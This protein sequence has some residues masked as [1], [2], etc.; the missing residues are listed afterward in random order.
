MCPILIF[1]QINF[2][3]I[4][5]QY[6]FSLQFSTFFSPFYLVQA[7]LLSIQEL[8]VP[9]YQPIENSIVG[10]FFSLKFLILHQFLLTGF[11]IYQSHA[12][13]CFSFNFLLFFT[14]TRN[15]SVC[16]CSGTC[17]IVH[18]CMARGQT[19]LGTGS[20]FLPWLNKDPLFLL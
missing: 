2:N 20:Y 17:V 18:M 14:Y 4:S 7:Y 12:H 5:L 19:G 10:F 1:Q 3:T 15:L 6:S 13:F 9:Y 16:A 11:R 8:L